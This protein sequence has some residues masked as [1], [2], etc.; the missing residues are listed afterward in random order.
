MDSTGASDNGADP[1]NAPGKGDT[2]K[3]LAKYLGKGNSSKKELSMTT[4]VF[5]SRKRGTM[6]FYVAGDGKVRLLCL[7][8]TM[9]AQRLGCKL[10]GCQCDACVEADW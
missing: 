7:P 8:S 9:P 1:V 6:S 3:T 10:A 2:F 5:S 4:P